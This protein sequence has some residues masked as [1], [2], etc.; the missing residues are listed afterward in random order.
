MIRSALKFTDLDSF[1]QVVERQGYKGEVTN[2]LFEEGKLPYAT[3]YFI[4]VQLLP[5]GF[6]LTL[7]HA[8]GGHIAQVQD[9]HS[10][11]GETFTQDFMIFPLSLT[12]YLEAGVASDATFASEATPNDW[13]EGEM[14]YVVN[15]EDGGGKEFFAT[16]DGKLVAFSDQSEAEPQQFKT[17]KQARKKIDQMREKYPPT[18]RIFALELGEFEERR[19]EVKPSK[20]KLSD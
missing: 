2:L 5:A 19:Q 8:F 9:I 12:G 14:I 15:L 7:I 10:W 6:D 16:A 17:F 4:P 3:A 18:C 13:P 20:G 1:L 11:G